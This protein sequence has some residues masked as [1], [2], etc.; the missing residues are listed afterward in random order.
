VACLASGPLSTHAAELTAGERFGFGANWRRF[1]SLVDEERIARAQASLA[2]S[3]QVPSLAGRR[4]LDAGCGSGLFS[5]A[6]TRLGASCRLVRLRSRVGGVRRGAPRSLRLGRGLDDSRRLRAPT[7]PS[8]SR[9]E[10][11]TSSTRGRPAP[12]RRDV[13]GDGPR[14]IARDGRRS[15]PRRSV[16]RSGRASR[17]WLRVKTAY[18]L[19]P[20][21]LRSLVLLPSFADP[22]GTALRARDAHISPRSCV[23]ELR[24]ERAGAC[25]R[26]VTSSTGSAGCPSKSRDRRRSWRSGLQR[27]FE[28]RGLNGP[29]AAATGATKFVFLRQV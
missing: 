1:L 11:S 2:S 10:R 24:R 19:P 27:G 21:P 26:G 18:N 16:Q 29:R 15:P 23:E 6:A 13:D 17:R 28:L 22:V 7:P 9:S 12:H 14:R 4:F 20:G 5:L 25:R 3:L 8:S